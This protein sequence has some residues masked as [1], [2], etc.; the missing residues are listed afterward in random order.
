MIEPFESIYHSRRTPDNCEWN[1]QRVG[2][3]IG[4]DNR[5]TITWE[6]ERFENGLPSQFPV[7]PSAH[8]SHCLVVFSDGGCIGLSKHQAKTAHAAR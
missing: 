8:L 4:Q 6:T 3:E 7:Q 2:S 5:G 1:P